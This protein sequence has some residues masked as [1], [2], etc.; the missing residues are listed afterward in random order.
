M[1]ELGRLLN[2]KTIMIMIAAAFIC[3]AAVVARDFS[4]CGIDNYNV[5]VREYHWL[6]A[7][8]TDDERKQHL[9][10]LSSDERRIY[11]RLAKEYDIRTEYIEGYR[12]NVNAVI[13]NAQN[14]KKFSVFGTTDSVANIDKTERDYSRIKDVNVTK[15]SSRAI[16]QYLQHDISIYVMLALMIYVIYNIYEYRDNGMW[17]LTYTAKNGRMRF[18]ACSVAAM[19]IIIAVQMFIMNICAAG[20]MLCIYGGNKILTE[21]VQCLTGYSSYTLP[22][23]VITYLFIR[24]FINSMIII[25]L[26]LIVSVIFA[27]CRKRISSVVIVGI[28][29][30]IEAYAYQNISLQ[31]R[32]RIFRKIN[33][34]NIMDVNAMLKDYE[35]IVYG[36][37]SA[38]MAAMLC[39]VCL[40]ISV[41]MMSI[42]IIMGK[43]IRP[44]K[45]TGVIDKIIEKIRHGIQKLLGQLPHLCKEIYKLLITGKGWLVIAVVGFITIFICN[46]QKVIYSDD[47]KKKDEY[48]QEYGGKDY[49]GFTE[50]IELRKAE[51]KEAAEKLEEAQEQFE[52]GEIDENT[53]SKYV[54]NYMDSTRLLDSMNE[55]ME[56]IN[57]VEEVNA[58]YGIEAYVMSQRGYNQI[59]GDNAK[60]RKLIIYIILGFG[61]VLIAESENALE[62]KSG[63][64]MLLGSSARGRIWGKAVKSGAVCIIAA[65]IAVIVNITEM[66]V[67]SHTYGMPYIDAPLISLSFMKVGKM[68]RYITIKQYMIMQLGVYILYSLLVSI[69]TMAVSRYIFKKNSNREVPLLIVLNTIVLFIII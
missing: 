20:G 22:V 36:N 51:V 69:E 7:G 13:S 67:M 17:Q 12:D 14:M 2:K 41:L 23:S 27:L 28:I 65:I 25:T 15:V 8:H 57:Y 5:K 55:Y 54:Y 63:M 39:V 16:E 44:G 18:S 29:A 53:V 45:K 38:G 21:P 46:S 43:Y 50:I 47:E 59:L 61:I 10:S 49:S 33:I 24:Y 56:Q 32:F 9:D 34:I 40:V 11:K 30:G 6:E 4:D 68:L 42:L 62:Y 31:S 48:Y 3:V 19:F 66:S 35:N 64:N 58:Q 1:K 26:S 60:I 37:I 52:K